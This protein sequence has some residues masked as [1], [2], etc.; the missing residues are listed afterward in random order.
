M[1]LAN[2]CLLS[3]AQ[4]RLWISDLRSGEFVQ[5]KQ[6]LCDCQGYCCLGVLAQRLGTLEASQES[7]NEEHVVRGKNVLGHEFQLMTMNDNEGKDF[8][9]IA[10]WIEVNI[11]PFAP[12]EMV[13]E[14]LDPAVP[15]SDDSDEW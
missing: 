11:L 8:F 2:K 5:T 4:I 6:S 1:T 14:A 10:D 7:G 3:K 12:D 13:P 15:G 9:T